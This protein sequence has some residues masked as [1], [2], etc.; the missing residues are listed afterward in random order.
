[1]RFEQRHIV[2]HD[3]LEGSD[4][5]NE[6]FERSVFNLVPN[7]S[8]VLW[9]LLTVKVLDL[10]STESEDISEL[11]VSTPLSQHCV[12]ETADRRTENEPLRQRRFQLAIHSFLVRA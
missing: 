3:L 8:R 5:E 1:M 2:Q 4:C 6:T 9:G 11:Y 12:R 7:T 10:G